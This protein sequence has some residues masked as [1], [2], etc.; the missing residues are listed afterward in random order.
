[1]PDQLPPEQLGAGS[2]IKNLIDMLGMVISSLFL[3]RLFDAYRR[4]AQPAA[5]GN[6]RGYWPRLQPSR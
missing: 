3:G 6:H 4:P 2:G 1:M 5:G